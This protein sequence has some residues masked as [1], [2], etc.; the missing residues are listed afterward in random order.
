MFLRLLLCYRFIEKPNLFRNVYGHRSSI[1]QVAQNR[2]SGKV[3]NKLTLRRR[4]PYKKLTLI[5]YKM[6]LQNEI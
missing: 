1:L 4:L 6:S 3:K 2:K 5:E